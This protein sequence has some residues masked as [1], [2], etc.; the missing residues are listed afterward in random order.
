MEAEIAGMGLALV[1]AVLGNRLGYAQAFAQGMGVAEA[2]PKSLAAR[3]FA[4]LAAALLEI[5]G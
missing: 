5:A 2:S 1:P 4:A 3:E